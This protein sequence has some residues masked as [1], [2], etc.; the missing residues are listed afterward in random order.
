MPGSDQVNRNLRDRTARQK[1]AIR[2]LG[3][4]AVGEME[5]YAKQNA[6]WEDQTGEARKGLFGYV[7]SR[8]A[9][10]ILRIAHGVGYGVYLELTNQGKY[11]ILNPTAKRFAPQFFDEL[12][13]LVA[14]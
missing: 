13:K 5:A 6:Q 7:L 8:E 2:A 9:S 12:R 3:E 11:A 14:R 10:M 4:R 1:A